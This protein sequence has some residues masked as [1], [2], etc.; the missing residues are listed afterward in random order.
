MP[1]TIRQKADT[2][3]TFRH[4]TVAY[5]ETLARWVPTTREMEVKILFGR[6]TWELA[7][8][9][10][11]LGQRTHELRA[12]LHYSRPSSPGY[13]QVTQRLASAADTEDRVR[14]MYEAALPDLDGRYAAYLDD[15]DEMLDEPT[16]RIIERI[17]TDLARMRAEAD[18]CVREC[19]F[20]WSGSDLATSL[21]EA[22]AAYPAFDFVDFRPERETNL[23]IFQ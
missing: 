13:D 6:H 12:A 20:G 22:F 18:Q 11:A 19:S 5:M 21:R 17:R 2:V 9:A 4:L 16:V 15:T 14:G 1:L 3:G 8:H 10:D 23:E 7:Q